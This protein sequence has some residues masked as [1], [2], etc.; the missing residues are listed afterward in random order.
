VFTKQQFSCACRFDNSRLFHN[1]LHTAKNTVLRALR[2]P[3]DASRPSSRVPPTRNVRCTSP[4]TALNTVAHD[5]LLQLSHCSTSDEHR[6]IAVG[7][8]ARGS[9]LPQ[10]TTLYPVAV[11]GTVWFKGSLVDPDPP[12][13]SRFLKRTTHAPYYPT[14]TPPL[15]FPFL[16]RP[17]KYSTRLDAHPYKRGCLQ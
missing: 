2:I 16:N 7:A 17:S 15:P 10:S 6:V 1:R 5:C 4:P 8:F 11:L 13:L 9:E 14:K 12:K 3:W